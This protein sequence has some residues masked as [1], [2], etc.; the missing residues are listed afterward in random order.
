MPEAFTTPAIQFEGADSKN[1][2]AFKHYEADAR[3]EGKTMREHLRFA[4]AYW[5][6]MRNPLADPFG[7]GTAEKPRDGGSESP[8]NALRRT[9][10]F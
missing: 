9:G 1:P 7:V 5:R 8:D 3:I 10:V 4:C 6:T 2:L